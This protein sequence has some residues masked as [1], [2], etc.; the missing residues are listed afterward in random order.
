MH[1]FGYCGLISRLENL[2]KVSKKQE[3]YFVA[4]AQ[5]ELPAT[6]LPSREKG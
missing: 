5:Y 1:I 4:Q 3:K 6:K 2:F